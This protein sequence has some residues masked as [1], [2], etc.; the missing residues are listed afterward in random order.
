MGSFFMSDKVLYWVSMTLGGLGLLILVAN[1]C[2]INSNRSMQI[3]LGQRQAAINNAANL[4]Q[5][6]QALI[7]AL[8]QSAVNDEDKDIKDLLT[9]QGITLKPKSA[10][11]AAAPADTTEKKK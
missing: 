3:D 2:L 9:S 6:N 5:L 8:A 1:V 11:T 10:A 7:Q 4:N